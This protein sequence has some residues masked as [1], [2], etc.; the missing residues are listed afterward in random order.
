VASRV[1]GSAGS[2]WLAVA[3]T[4]LALP[5][6]VQAETVPYAGSLGVA[7]LTLSAQSASRVDLH[8]EL[9]ALTLEP[10]SI[11][12]QAYTHLAIPEA[13][14]PNDAG[15]PDLPG[16]SRMIAIPRGAVARLEILN[17]RTEVRSG[18]RVSPA[19]VIPR[20][21]EDGP[22]VYAE[23]ADLYS[24]DAAFP[25]APV[26][27]SPPG[28]LRGVDFVTLGVTPFAYNPVR[29]E[30]TVFTEL[31]VRV[32]FDGGAGQFGEERLRSRFWEPILAEHLL[33]YATLAPVDFSARSALKDQRDGWEYF[34]ICPDD[35]AFMA[36]A[37][38]LKAWRKLQGISTRVFTLTEVGGNTTAAIEAFVNNAY[39]T[40]DPAPSAFLLLGDYPQG[41]TPGITSPTF[42]TYYPCKSDNIYADVDGDNL[43]ELA[44]AR[45]TGRNQA[46]LAT[47]IGK[48]LSYERA[49]Y[50][51]PTFYAH[52]VIAGG[53]QTERWFILCTEVCFGHQVNVLGKQPVREYAIYEG[54][55]G[56]QWSSATNTNT[57]VNYFGPNGLGYI[58]ATPQHLTDWGANATRVNA[59]INAG[60][61]M[62]LHRDHGFEQGWGEPDYTTS[63]L[64]G[65]TNTKFPFVFS[66][67]CLTGKYDYSSEVFTERF[68]RMGYGA[69]GLTA[70][71]E[72]SYSFVNDCL[73]WGMWDTM[74]PEFMPTYG[75][76]NPPTH[77]DKAL[78]PCFAMVSGKY[79]L[80]SSSWPYNTG[81]K[82]DTYH[83]FHH[84]GDAFQPMYTDVPRN[85][86][87]SHDDVCLIGTAVFHAQA[88]AGALIGLTID[89][90][91]V[92]TADATGLPQEI[93]IVPPAE[94]GV[95][96]VTVT[97]ANCFR[98][99]Y[100]VPVLPPSGPYLVFEAAE[101]L[102]PGGD[103]DGH[104]D[105]AEADELLL[106]LKNVGIDPTSEGTA[107]LATD[108][109]YITIDDGQAAAPGIPAGGTAPL[110]DMFA[111]TVAGAVPDQRAIPFSV[112]TVT[113]EGTW[114]A[115]F[116]LISQAPVLLAGDAVVNDGAPYGNGDG[117]LDPGEHFLMQ[118][119]I[120]NTGHA[121]AREL[122]GS[123]TST[124]LNLTVVQG[125]GNADLIPAGG[126]GVLGSFEVEI[127]PACPSPSMQTL[128]LSVA[129]PGGFAAQ[130]SYPV[131]I[132]P[133]LDTAE[134]DLGWSLG[135]AGD[136]ATSGQWV[137]DDPVG[138]VYN[139]EQTQ[140]EDDH[141]PAPGH[142]CF[143]TGNGSPGG[144]AGEADVD[145]GKTTLLSPV[146]NTENATS[147]DLSYWRW[148]TNDLGNN[149]GQ[150]W[151][152]VD[153]SNDGTTWTHLEYT[154]ESANSWTEHTFA[155]DEIAPVTG[156]LQLR[157]IADDVSPGSLVE[158]AVDDITVTILR[159]LGE[160]APDAPA[161]ADGPAGIVSCR[162]NPFGTQAALTFRLN[163][164]EA[165]RVDLY[166][167]SGR[168]VRTLLQGTPEA[169]LHTLAFE[170][171][172]RGGRVLPSG[173]YFLRLETPH[174]TQ[175][176]Q[177][178]LVR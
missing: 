91:I 124:S 79:F 59:D 112:E 106:T 13:L 160:D 105:Y 147:I 82:A 104:L 129:G 137:R 19:P 10:V 48:M 27:L 141:T 69:V 178:T 98:Y 53:W 39:N 61:Y 72:V 101:V 159:Q 128:N 175:V 83:L 116:A 25:E 11:N 165:A 152:T 121:D 126:E 149:P 42:Q 43:P 26:L 161:A 107:T 64:S 34:I 81:N 120:A 51:D 97:K 1:H 174:L 93:P 158:A 14:L 173:I 66:M 15:A 63:D 22:L 84:H 71:S 92:G 57:V 95:L 40:W 67:N 138:A 3:L 60:A 100:D 44:H 127:S 111:I 21:N 162:P 114:T 50:T 80:Q 89:G 78:R 38:T 117:L 145:G 144:A 123:L 103:A 157:F 135:V 143:V 110:T 28:Q 167:V 54:T 134:T 170:G 70:A 17:A 77:F 163:R 148:Y 154:Q 74:W 5:M 139:G 109:P 68:H 16:V 46:E 29:G 176:R 155:L 41:S 150:D 119:W 47:M 31:D 12:G 94:P 133:W 73:I 118:V 9:G 49:P 171:V 115:N 86:S 52:P 76:Y 140:P 37:D 87:V 58:P 45:I 75:P 146:F 85:V 172:D 131:S 102:D 23:N 169:G 156:T 151:W 130:L 177:V 30:L 132:G 108:D 35:P 168:R 18:L 136:G 6:D 33:N 2:V 88:E 90:E 65:L 24:R 7:G 55:P 62:V 122:I 164:R 125:T 36:W 4:L 153:F 99:V 96:R 32:H 56:T 20:E 8:F 142:I 113:P 166:D